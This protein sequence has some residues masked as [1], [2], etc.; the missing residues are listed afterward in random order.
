[1]KLDLD[2]AGY[3]LGYTDSGEAPGVEY[4]GAVPEQFA[5]TCRDYRL[6]AGALVLDPAR[7]AA[8][9]AV[10]A[11]WE[12]RTALL[13]WFRWYDNQCMQYQRALRR[14]EAFDRDI[15]ALDAQA[16]ASQARMRALEQEYGGM[17]QD[18]ETDEV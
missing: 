17:I 14:Q 6:E 8:R 7:A 16:A 9:E 1:M 13:A 10:H 12:E 4:S 15:T 11:A 18:G 2:P 5:E 3:V